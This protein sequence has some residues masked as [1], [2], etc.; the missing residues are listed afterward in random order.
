MFFVVYGIYTRERAPEYI[1]H[2]EHKTLYNL[3]SPNPTVYC[4]TDTQ[5]SHREIYILYSYNM[6]I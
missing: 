3:F 5:A 4:V 2:S 6:Y 1:I